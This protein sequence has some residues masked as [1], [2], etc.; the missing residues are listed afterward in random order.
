MLFHEARA[1]A[2][3]PIQNPVEQLQKLA[4]QHSEEL[5]RRLSGTDGESLGMFN[6]S[7][8]P[9]THESSQAALVAESSTAGVLSPTPVKAESTPLALERQLSANSTE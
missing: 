2:T 1:Q 5:L 3:D 7:G 8:P 4:A 9:T 6:E